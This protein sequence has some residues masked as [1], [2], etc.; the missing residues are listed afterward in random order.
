MKYSPLHPTLT[1][2]LGDEDTHQLTAQ[3][4][5]LV[6]NRE[7]AHQPTGAPQIRTPVKRLGT[8]DRERVLI[9][10]ES[11]PS[12][13]TLRTCAV[14]FPHSEGMAD[15]WDVFGSDSDEDQPAAVT[16]VSSHH[17]ASVFPHHPARICVFWA[18]E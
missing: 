5:L 8:A 9:T 4:V 7:V 17:R 6:Q 1:N 16:T 13:A 3:D 15:P 12:P 14:V 18:H 2:L 10:A 11:H